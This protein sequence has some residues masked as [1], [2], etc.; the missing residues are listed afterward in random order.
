MEALKSLAQQ[1][2][3]PGDA[4][5]TAGELLVEVDAAIA[6]ALP[7]GKRRRAA[8]VLQEVLAAGGDSEEESEEEEEEVLDWR[9]KTV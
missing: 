5:G 3:N 9:A 8:D 4:A 1:R 7:A 6:A 2:S